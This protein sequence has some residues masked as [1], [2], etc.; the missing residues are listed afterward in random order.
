MFCKLQRNEEFRFSIQGIGTAAIA[1]CFR[2]G[3][4]SVFMDSTS[5]SV[6][7]RSLSLS[8]FLS[9]PLSLYIYLSLSLRLSV[10]LSLLHALALLPPLGRV[11]V[12]SPGVGA[13]LDSDGLDSRAAFLMWIAFQVLQ[14]GISG[15]QA[16]RPLCSCSDPGG[17]HCL[18]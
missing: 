11:E 13:A 8:P 17:Y 1:V 6:P 16:A 3:T 15:A 4:E 14:G 9:L 2:A 10:S 5:F 7:L 12:L 18:E